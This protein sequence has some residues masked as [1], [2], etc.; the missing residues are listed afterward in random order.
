MCF[1]K[2]LFEEII[3]YCQIIPYRR[4]DS[5]SIVFIVSSLIILWEKDVKYQWLHGK[6]FIQ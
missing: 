3:N 6:D 2:L 1:R 5:Q 4:Q